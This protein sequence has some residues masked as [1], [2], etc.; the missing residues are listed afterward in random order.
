MMRNPRLVKP[1]IEYMN[2]YFLYI[3]DEPIVPGEDAYIHPRT[4]MEPGHEWL[5]VRPLKVKCIATLP[6]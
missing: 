2:S 5:T 4:T 6:G 1:S 3:I